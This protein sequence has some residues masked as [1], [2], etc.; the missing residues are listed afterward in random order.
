MRS[1]SIRDIAEDWKDALE[2]TIQSST[3][4]QTY[5]WLRLDVLSNLMGFDAL[6]ITSGVFYTN[7]TGKLPW[8]KI[9]DNSANTVFEYTIDSF[10]REFA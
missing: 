7:A 8:L 6:D 1:T 9:I 2:N 10:V 5:D 4:V 3:T